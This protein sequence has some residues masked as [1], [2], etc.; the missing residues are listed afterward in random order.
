MGYDHEE[1]LKFIVVGTRE[2]VLF[3]GH[4]FVRRLGQLADLLALVPFSFEHALGYLLKIYEAIAVLR[5]AV[6]RT[7]PEEALLLEVELSPAVA[8]VLFK[9]AY[10]AVTILELI[11]A[12]P[13]TF[14]SDQATLKFVAILERL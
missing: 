3:N 4:F 6:P 10:I 12:I 11:R 14:A 9:F 7:L 13:F 8:L 5:A 2:L 1:S